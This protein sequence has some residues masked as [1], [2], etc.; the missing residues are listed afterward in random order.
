MGNET[1]VMEYRK[2]Y[3]N[4][5]GSKTIEKMGLAENIIPTLKTADG[6]DYSSAFLYVLAVYGNQQLKKKGFR[7]NK[8]AD[9]AAE[10]MPYHLLMDFIGQLSG[11]FDFLNNPSLLPIFCRYATAKDIMALIEKQDGWGDLPKPVFGSKVKKAKELLLDSM[12]LNESKEGIL[13]LIENGDIFEWGR[14]RFQTMEELYEDYLPDFGFDSNGVR[15]F[16]FGDR[17]IRTVLQNNYSLAFY[18]ELSGTEIKDLTSYEFVE[19]GQEYK[20]FVD[21]RESLVD[22]YNWVVGQLINKFVNKTSVS[23]K[24]W[25]CRCKNPVLRF[26]YEKLIWEQ[27]GTRFVFSDDYRF[28][29]LEGGDYK[30]DDRDII[31]AHPMEMSEE[32][33]HAWQTYFAEKKIVQPFRQ[34]WEPVYQKENI[35]EDRYSGIKI[36]IHDLTNQKNRGIYTFWEQKKPG[37]GAKFNLLVPGL[38]VVFRRTE[39]FNGI[40]L[41]KLEV[42]DWNRKTNAVIS[43]LDRC[44]L[45]E[46][47]RNDDIEI[48]E[49]VNEMTY[50]Q[51][52]E[53]IKLAQEVHANT[54]LPLLIDWKR[55]KYGDLDPMDEFVLTVE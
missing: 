43:Y 20:A 49:Q 45:F 15:M 40:D 29:T 50:E 26:A 30:L 34:V 18:D 11:G 35:R 12:V 19:N 13:W 53:G 16:V 38:K 42:V 7:I 27:D 24:D 51:F 48:A 52:C 22:V 36:F 4:M 25:C 47:I 8:E 46:R 44:T 28:S 31:L 10:L 55:K 6:T 14:Q 23:A 9:M 21:V 32:E 54:V 41:Y 5:K 2:L 37:S 1:T 33:R 17:K 3:D 39:D